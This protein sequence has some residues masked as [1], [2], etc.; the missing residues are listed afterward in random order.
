MAEASESVLEDVRVVLEYAK[1]HKLLD[2]PALQGSN[3]VF[4]PV[5]AKEKFLAGSDYLGVA[6]NF[7]GMDLLKWA[8]KGQVVAKVAA[9]AFGKNTSWTPWRST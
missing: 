9:R 4:D 8:V 2:A 7:F 1:E 3:T 5:A 6:A